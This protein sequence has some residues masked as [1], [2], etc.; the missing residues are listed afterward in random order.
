MQIEPNLAPQLAQQLD[1]AYHDFL[2]LT[3]DWCGRPEADE[4]LHDLRVAWRRA[5]SVLDVLRRGD[6]LEP[7]ASAVESAVKSVIQ[8]SSPLRDL[9]VLLQT[10][11]QQKELAPLVQA[12]IRRRAD[13]ARQVVDQWH[14][15]QDT[16]T[17]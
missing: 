5:R 15:I 4:L 1:S 3:D 8:Q 13:L 10:A 16:L 12:I 6:S 17:S 9:D 11:Q 7:A 14:R 2:R